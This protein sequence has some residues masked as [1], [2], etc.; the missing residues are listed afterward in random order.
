MSKRNTQQEKTAA[1]ERLRAERERQAKKEARNRQLKVGGGVL[2]VLVVAGG[3]VFGVSQAS[4]GGSGSSDQW[5]SAKKD[6][7]VKP[8]NASG[9]DGTTVVV[10]KAGAKKTLQMYEDPRCPVCAQFEQ[11]VGSTVDKAVEDGTYK[12][13]YIGATFLDGNLGGS[14]SKNALSALGAALDVSPDAFWHYKAAMYAKDNHPDEQKDTF[15]SDAALIKIAD[16]VPELKGNKAF[17]K[18]VKDGTFDKWA[19]TMS[20]K[21]DKSGVQA[22]PTLQMDG[23]KLTSPGS[24]NAPMTVAEFTN[25]LNPLLKG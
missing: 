22:T 11:T 20:E 6:P 21:F 14:G 16:Q 3:V 17:Q 2:A 25:A 19:L 18:D 9:K 13:Q 1:R 8:K 5:A 4:G 15:N 7:L 23:K 12:V 10:G 24:E